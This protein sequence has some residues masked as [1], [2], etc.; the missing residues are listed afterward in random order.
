[1]FIHMDSLVPSQKKAPIYRSSSLMQYL[2]SRSQS[3]LKKDLEHRREALREHFTPVE[4]EFAFAKSRDIYAVEEI[5]AFLDE[6]I[7]D[8]CEGLMVKMMQGEDA[9][10]E[11]SRRSMNWLKVGHPPSL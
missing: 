10:Y 5:Q 2:R 9:T 1:M 11:P 8:S 3:M 7:K 6:S 4:G